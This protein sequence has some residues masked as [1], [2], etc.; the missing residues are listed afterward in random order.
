MALAIFLAVA[1]MVGFASPVWAQNYAAGLDAYDRGDFDEAIRILRPLAESGD[2]RAQYGLGK[3]YETGGGPISPDA[4]KAVSWYSKS[5][6]QG[7]AAAQN[8]LALMYA[9]GR[10]VPQN[11]PQ[12]FALWESSARGGHSHAQYNMG[13]LFYRGEG[14]ERDLSVAANWFGLAAENGLPEAQFAVAEMH[15]LGVGLPQDDRRALGWYLMAAGQGHDAARSQ[16]GRLRDD[17]VSPVEVAGSFALPAG[18]EKPV[19]IASAA[20]APADAGA[21]PF[22]VVSAPKPPVPPAPESVAAPESH[23]VPQA[24][25]AEVAEVAVVEATPEPIPAPAPEPVSPQTAQ[26]QTDAVQQAAAQ[27]APVPASSGEFWLWLGSMSSEGGALDLSD[28]LATLYESS[29]VGADLAVRRVEVG[30]S[31]VFYRVVAGAWPSIADARSVCTALRH[32]DPAVFCKV[33]R[34]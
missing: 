8:N 20:G 10:G 32:N 6:R 31:D 18:M 23:S 27:L 9:E 3:I 16:A 14:V 25:P 11:K 19:Q 4:G 15:R 12:A 29:L 13:L 1:A 26:P 22:A 33:V 30:D 28:S 17:G 34:D 21:A 5:A 7:I 24:E 2:A